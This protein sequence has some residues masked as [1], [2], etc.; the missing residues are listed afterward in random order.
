MQSAPGAIV[1]DH[2]MVSP[3]S[4]YG[5]ISRKQLGV[6]LVSDADASNISIAAI[7][8]LNEIRD[9]VAPYVRRHYERCH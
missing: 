5:L 4:L 9:M 3:A 2:S 6:A 1:I 8:A 7:A